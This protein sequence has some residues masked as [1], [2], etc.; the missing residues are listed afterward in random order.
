MQDIIPTSDV[1][2][3]GGG[4]AGTSVAYHLARSGAGKIVLLEKGLLASGSTAHSAAIVRQHYANPT[5]ARMALESLEVFEQFSD[6]VGGNADFVRTGFMVG[7]GPDNVEEL[8]A[9]VAVQRSVGV[10]VKVF[11]PEDIVQMEPLI[12]TRGL[13]AVAYEPESGYV[14]AYSVVMSYAG[15]ARAMGARIYQTT[16]AIDV[17]VRGSRVQGVVTARGTISTSVVVNA[18]G[19]WAN[20]IGEM[21][22][23]RWPLHL[24]AHHAVVF[25]VPPQFDYTP[26]IFCDMVGRVYSRPE[27]GD[28][29]VVGSTDEADTEVIRE[30]GDLNRAF[31]KPGL[32]FALELSERLGRRYPILR[33]HG[34]YRHGWT[35]PI[36]RT[37][38]MNMIL[39]SAE[40]VDGL[41]T[42]IGLSGH[43]FKLC[44]VIGRLMAEIVLEGQATDVDTS[45][46]RADRFSG[47]GA[48]R[49]PV[50]GHSLLG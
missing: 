12:S 26:T 41:Y 35:G 21:V 31:G 20:V 29:L 47:D 27:T 10:E 23:I 36:A 39:G 28:C 11:G 24:S 3:I 2:I 34:T 4:C 19:P 14:D 30:P 40:Q 44:P 8:L 25:G 45:L 46:F 16:P 48:E 1:V 33:D 9:A 22:G 5:T 6:V 38:D 32:E 37:P 17:V 42:A 15:A 13:A 50:G 43:G 49:P 18:A 7:V